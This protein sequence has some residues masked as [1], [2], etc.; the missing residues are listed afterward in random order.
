MGKSIVWLIFGGALA[1]APAVTIAFYL[2]PAER[3]PVE[4]DVAVPIA[5]DD[6]GDQ[7][8]PTS[9]VPIPGGADLPS[10]DE[11]APPVS[12]TPG[13]IGSTGPPATIP[14][15]FPEPYIPNVDGAGTDGLTD[16]GVA[17]PNA[18]AALDAD[19]SARMLR[20]REGSQVQNIVGSVSR[21]GVRWVFLPDSGGMPLG[22]LENQLRERVE[23]Y[24]SVQAHSGPGPKWRLSGIITEYRGGNFLLIT[25][26]TRLDP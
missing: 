18:P 19:E 7:A 15:S 23:H 10:V 14:N 3:A 13:A 17:E 26:A 20:R 9:S 25:A 1:L 5:S 11:L 24:Q 12:E 4:T 2:G 22:L 8:P 16:L 21:E 6:A